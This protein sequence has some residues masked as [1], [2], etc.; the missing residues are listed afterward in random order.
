MPDRD[1]STPVKVNNRNLI[2]RRIDNIRSSRVG[3][4]RFL[5]ANRGVFGIPE[6]VDFRVIG[7]ATNRREGDEGV[8]PTPETIIQYVWDQYLEV[9]NVG[10]PGEYLALH[11]GGTLAIDDNVNVL[12]WMPQ[13]FPEERLER[14]RRH[15]AALSAAEEIDM[16]PR[17]NVR[18][19]RLVEV[20]REPTGAMRLRINPA[21]MHRERGK[22]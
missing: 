15:V 4:Y 2:Q 5:N 3:A 18:S 12:Y 7:M 6:T 19:D 11:P 13:F 20:A 9:P 14:V 16:E 17:R 21:L 10:M 22:P 1:T 8:L